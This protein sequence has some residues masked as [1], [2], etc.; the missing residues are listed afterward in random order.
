MEGVHVVG[1]WPGGLGDISPPW[2]PGQ[3]PGRGLGDEVP[4]KLKHNVK[5]SVQLLTFFCRKFRI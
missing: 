4:Q 5:I 3:S 2:G 1:A